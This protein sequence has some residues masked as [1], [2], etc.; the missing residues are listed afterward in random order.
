VVADSSR[1]DWRSRV[2]ASGI[3][4]HSTGCF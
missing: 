3:G 2:H 1:F 4:S